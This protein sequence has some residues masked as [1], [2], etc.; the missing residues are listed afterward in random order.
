MR[1][2][3]RSRQWRSVGGIGVALVA[4]VVLAACGSSAAS[5]KTPATR[6]PASAEA[7]TPASAAAP[8]AAPTA[9]TPSAPAMTSPASAAASPA[10]ASAASAAASAMGSPAASSPRGSAMASAAVSVTVSAG[11]SAVTSAP[12]MTVTNAWVRETTDVTRPGGG[13]LTLTNG[14]EE[15]DALVG[16]TSPAAMSVQ[17][18]ETFADA[19]GMMAMRPI[20]QLPVPAGGS[21]ELKPGGYHLMLMGLKQPLAAGQTVELTLTFEHA[22]PVT[23]QA[24]VKPL[25]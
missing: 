13:Y 17:V 9:M 7:S 21:V 15:A 11:A 8:T 25:Q 2:L 1:R 19:S 23:V 14:T 22:A 3:G 12:G 5:P 20:A 4:G 6:V 10:M 24:P 16:V 18:H